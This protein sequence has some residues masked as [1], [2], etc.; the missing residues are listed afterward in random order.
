[1]AVSKM[2]KMQLQPEDTALSPAE[3]ESYHQ[4]VPGWEIITADGEQ[5]LK[6]VFKFKDFTE[7]L[8]FTDRV[9]ATAN[10]QNHHPA[11]LTEWGKVTVFWWTHKVHGLHVNDFIMAAKT[12]RLSE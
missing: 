6:R 8:A 7:A 2:D 4:Q 3:I 11:L 10:Q 5:Q 12:D 9:G 1:M